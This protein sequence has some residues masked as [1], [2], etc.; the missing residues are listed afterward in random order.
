M[1]PEALTRS[2]DVERAA[3]VQYHLNKVV[4]DV[5]MAMKVED[6][7]DY[8]KFKSTLF[9]VDVNNSEEQY[10]KEFINWRQQENESVEAI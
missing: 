6:T 7:D 1:P 3:M 4:E 9:M 5:L 2:S 8:D 10:M